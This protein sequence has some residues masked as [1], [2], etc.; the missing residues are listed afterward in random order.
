MTVLSSA[1]HGGRL[2]RATISIRKRWSARGIAL[3]VCCALAASSCGKNVEPSGDLEATDGRAAEP[4]PEADG[5][6]DPH[7]A[8]SCPAGLLCRAAT[9][10]S[11][12]VCAPTSSP[13]AGAPDAVDGGADDECL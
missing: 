3:A 10:G 8:A 2:R 1:A 9:R 11:G 13:D 12:N 7:D 6:C 4:E 5:S